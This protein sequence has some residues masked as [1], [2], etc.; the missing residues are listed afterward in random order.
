M[1]GYSIKFENY[2]LGKYIST[3]GWG[4]EHH[5]RFFKRSEVKMTGGLV[6][7]GFKVEDATKTLNQPIL[8][9]TYKSIHQAIRKVNHYSTLEAQTRFREEK[10]HGLSRLLLQSSKSFYQ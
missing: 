9:F 7:E 5:M 3:C 4:K 1:S 10:K 6:H 2:F 8:H